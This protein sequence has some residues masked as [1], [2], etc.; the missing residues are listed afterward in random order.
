C[1]RCSGWRGAG[2][3]HGSASAAVLPAFGELRADRAGADGRGPQVPACLWF[4]TRK[5]RGYLK[6]DEKSHGSPHAFNAKEFWQLRA[7]FGEK[8]G[9]SFEGAGK[10]A[11]ADRAGRVAQTRENLQR[12]IS[13]L[14]RHEKLRTFLSDRLV[15]LG[16]SVPATLPTFTW[17]TSRDP[18]SDARLT[19]PA[20]LPADIFFKPGEKQPNRA[21]FAR[22]GAYINALGHE[23]YGRP[24]F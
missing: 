3:G 2:T 6:Y 1:F 24:L 13:A 18:C 10:D 20:R 4:R 8:Y 5:G 17:D 19:D 21:G 14:E 15:G 7:A 11:P 9:L 12:M 23:H 16:E 22:A